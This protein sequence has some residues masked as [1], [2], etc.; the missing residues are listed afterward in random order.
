MI[1][2]NAI[3]CKSAKSARAS[4]INDSSLVRASAI[5]LLAALFTLATP[6]GAQTK[7]KTATSRARRETGCQTCYNDVRQPPRAS[8]TTHSTAGGGAP[9]TATSS[10]KAPP[11][12]SVH[13]TK[14]GGEVA[15]NSRGQVTAYRGPNGHEAQFR[16]PWRRQRSSCQRHDTSAEDLAASGA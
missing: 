3:I 15:R 1:R 16:L 10:V 4:G 5:G 8:T 9:K 6:A 12:G 11:G 13:T 14:S 2:W 7:A